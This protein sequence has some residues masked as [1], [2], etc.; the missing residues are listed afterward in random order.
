MT[1][2]FAVRGCG[3]HAVVYTMQRG[4]NALSLRLIITL[5]E[6]VVKILGTLLPDLDCKDV[7]HGVFSEV[8]NTSYLPHR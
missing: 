6:I 8:H 2:F 3:A 7:L 5:V 1:G 4:T